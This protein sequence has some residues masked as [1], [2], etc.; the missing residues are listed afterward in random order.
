MC[1]CVDSC[2]FVNEQLHS[3]KK[4]TPKA[5]F[6]KTWC[7]YIFESSVDVFNS[8]YMFIKVNGIVYVRPIVIFGLLTIQN[9]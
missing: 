5:K 3:K 8:V 4:N 1:M 9:K 2:V 7:E 6:H